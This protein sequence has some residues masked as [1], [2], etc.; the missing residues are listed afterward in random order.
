MR[1]FILTFLFS[2]SGLTAQE[3]KVI[4]SFADTDPKAGQ[5]HISHYT[6]PM[7]AIE[8][9]FVSQ[10]QSLMDSVS[11]F[12]VA[13]PKLKLAI[14]VH[15]AEYGNPEHEDR[16][17]ELIGNAIKTGLLLKGIPDKQYKIESNGSSLPLYSHDYIEKARALRDTTDED[18]HY[19][20]TELNNRLEFVILKN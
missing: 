4:F 18:K 14:K 6:K 16:N 19:Q 2:F 11:T 10:N 7:S 3:K 17:T 20:L 13:H 8:S 9:G 1:V 15:S 12:L 5:F